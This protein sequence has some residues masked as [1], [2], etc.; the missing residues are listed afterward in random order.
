MRFRWP[1]IAAS[2]LDAL[3]QA[4]HAAS[5][6]LLGSAYDSSTPHAP[7]VN[8]ARNGTRCTKL[9]LWKATTSKGQTRSTP[10]RISR[11]E[12]VPEA[13]IY[14]VVGGG[15]TLGGCFTLYVLYALLAS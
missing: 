14:L 2:G 9:P 12:F 15:L 13:A 10:R 1:L 4:A 11:G 8:G 6:V 5:S 3:L 7:P